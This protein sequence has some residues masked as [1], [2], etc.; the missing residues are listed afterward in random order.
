MF[1]K[2]LS[3]CSKA[4]LANADRHVRIQGYFGTISLFF[5]KE[6]G[7]YVKIKIEMVYI[8]QNAEFSLINIFFTPLCLL[9]HHSA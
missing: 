9:L 6:I 5:L 3:I 1:R 8:V 7:L 2:N 4:K